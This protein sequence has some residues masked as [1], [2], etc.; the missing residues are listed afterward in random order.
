MT[1]EH[2]SLEKYTSHTLLSKWLR[3]GCVLEVSWRREKT[4][5]YWP[6]VPLTIA[7]LLSHSAGLLNRGF[8]GPKPTAGIWF[9][10]PRT[11]TRTATNRLQLIQAVCGTGLYNCLTT[12]CLPWRRNCTEFNPSRWYPDIFDDWRLG[13]RSICYIKSQIHS[14]GTYEYWRRLVW[15]GFVLWHIND[16]RSFNPEYFIYIYNFALIFKLNLAK[17]GNFQY[18]F[19][20]DLWYQT[21]KKP[22]NYLI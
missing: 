1:N 13:R 7:A 2:T 20:Y 17:T 10:L 3:K 15:F 22:L 4:A 9:S 18:I 16:C 11:A 5:T 19:V 21:L 8:W 6:Q 12:T 14:F